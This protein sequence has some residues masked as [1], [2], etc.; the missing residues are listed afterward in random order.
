MTRFAR[1]LRPASPWIKRERTPSRDWRRGG[2]RVSKAITA[3]WSDC[4]WRWSTLCCASDENFEWAR[5]CCKTADEAAKQSGRRTTGR[6]RL[7]F[8][9][10]R[11]FLLVGLGILH[12][13]LEVADAFTQAL[14]HGSELAG[15]EHQ[16]RDRDNQQQMQ[17][18][19]KALTH[20]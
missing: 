6:L 15:A 10:F 9:F 19:E 3:M 8:F 13:R 2:F 17:R 16:K 14:S 1:T 11:G 12:R 5:G 20:K 4:R 18:L 7:L